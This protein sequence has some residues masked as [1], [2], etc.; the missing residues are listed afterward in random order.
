M[1]LVV[2]IYILFLDTKELWIF[3][4][5]SLSKKSSNFFIQT[6]SSRTYIKFLQSP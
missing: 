5:W 4:D 3:W 2:L 1:V 6:I